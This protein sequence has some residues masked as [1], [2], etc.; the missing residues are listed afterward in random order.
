MGSS[1]KLLGEYIKGIAKEAKHDARRLR[2]FDF[3]DT[4]VKTDALVHVKDADGVTFDL[5][6]GE[7]AV[8]EK[9]QGDVFDYTDFQKLINP[10]VVKW[11]CKIMHS[12]Y[13]HHGSFGLVILSARS[14]SEPMEQFLREQGLV[15]VEVIA[16][17]NSSPHA[18]VA[19]IEDRI[20]RDRLTMIE[21]FDDSPKHIAAVK[22]MQ[23]KHPHIQVI[24]RHIV[25]RKISSLVDHS[26][27]M[28]IG[29]S[30]LNNTGKSNLESA[31]P[32]GTTSM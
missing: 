19:W 2:V 25:H 11:M 24:T 29:T 27:S 16:L 20:D 28:V 23:H 30:S 9:H 1:A 21:F 31:S 15:G 5:T 12:V 6:P 18:K 8:Y 3:D 10:R 13:T 14:Y 17:D 22:E 26:S 32:I 7:F 4:L